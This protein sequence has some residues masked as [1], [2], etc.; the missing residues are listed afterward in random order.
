MLF[1]NIASAA[2]E[3]GAEV[4]TAILE[5]IVKYAKWIAFVI[6]G[7]AFMMVGWFCLRAYGSWADDDNKQG[8]MPRLVLTIFLGILVLAVVTIFVTKG[9]TYLETN[10]VTT[11]ISPAYETTIA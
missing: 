10:I 5:N 4:T 11:S 1:P 7:I 2:D 3:T 8:T 6:I 9:V